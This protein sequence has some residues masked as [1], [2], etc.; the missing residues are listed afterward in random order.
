[1]VELLDNVNVG[2]TTAVLVCPSNLYFSFKMNSWFF[3]ILD[4]SVSD[5]K[6]LFKTFFFFFFNKAF[7]QLQIYLHFPT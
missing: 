3:H 5:S 4:I 6:H 7:Y 2:L 1:M